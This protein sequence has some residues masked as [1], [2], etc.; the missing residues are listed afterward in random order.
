MS[1]PDTPSIENAATPD[2]STPNPVDESSSAPRP[3][4][5]TWD[6]TFNELQSRVSTIIESIERQSQSSLPPNVE[7]EPEDDHLDDAAQS[8]QLGRDAERAELPL[9]MERLRSKLDPPANLSGILATLPE[10]TAEQRAAF[11]RIDHRLELMKLRTDATSDALISAVREIEALRQMVDDAA[12]N[13]ANS[14]RTDAELAA[15][16]RELAASLNLLHDLVGRATETVKANAAW[17]E[18]LAESPDARNQS[19]RDQL[20]ATTARIETKSTITLAAAAF[21]A[22]VAVVAMVI[23]FV[24]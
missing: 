9:L 11:G 20:T 1:S 5:S 10:I 24:H 4:T 7:P 15:N 14:Q 17:V 18:M 6:H 16:Q 23:A 13:V 8:L 12:K 21:A 19:I 2:T 22:L 3:G